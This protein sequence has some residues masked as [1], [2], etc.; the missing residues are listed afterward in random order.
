MDSFSDIR[1]SGFK[2]HVVAHVGEELSVGL[3]SPRRSSH[4]PVGSQAV[5]C[6]AENK[7]RC[8]HRASIG[9]SDHLIQSRSALSGSIRAAQ[10]LTMGSGV[11]AEQVFTGQGGVL[12]IS[13]ELPKVLA[14][15]KIHG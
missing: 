12:K 3:V 13:A 7:Q 9:R 14:R 11:C 15:T 2:H 4:L 6:C 1:P 8:G 10:D 5:V